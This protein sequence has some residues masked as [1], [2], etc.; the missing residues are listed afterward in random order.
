MNTFSRTNSV[1][2][3]NFPEPYVQDTMKHRAFTI[4]YSNAIFSIIRNGYPMRNIKQLLR[5]G[6]FNFGQSLSIL[7]EFFSRYSRHKVLRKDYILSRSEFHH[8]CIFA[9]RPCKPEPN[10]S[11]SCPLQSQSRTVHL[12]IQPIPT[13]E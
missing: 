10:P 5:I 12:L 3:I 8:V 13:K 9:D 6:Q 11:H 1:V 4:S 2:L 7:V